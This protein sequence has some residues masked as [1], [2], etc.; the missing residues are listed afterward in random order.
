MVEAAGA[1]SGGVRLH[2]VKRTVIAR[3]ERRERIAAGLS[4][5]K[6]VA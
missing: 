3:E 5:A 2:A 6:G 4:H 1:G